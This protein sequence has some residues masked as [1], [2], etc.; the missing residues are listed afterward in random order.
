MNY[1]KK[2]IE[3]QEGFNEDAWND[4]HASDIYDSDDLYEYMHQYIENSVIYWAECD[5]I[6]EN[7]SEYHYNEHD[8]W[9][10]PATIYQAAYACLYDYLTESDDTVVWSQMEEVLNEAE[11]KN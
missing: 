5:A 10:K 8:L 9:G 4:F 7:N 2:L 11:N 6:L 1:N 3:L